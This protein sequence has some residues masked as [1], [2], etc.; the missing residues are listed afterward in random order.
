[1]TSLVA[2]IRLIGAAHRLAAFARVLQ[3]PHDVL[4]ASPLYES[5]LPDVRLADN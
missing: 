3:A 1:M 5:T 2:V 4:P